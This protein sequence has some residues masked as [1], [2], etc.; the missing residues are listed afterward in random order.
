[1]RNSSVLSPFDQNTTCKIIQ[2]TQKKKIKK[3]IITF[4]S[5]KIPNNA[6]T[7]PPVIIITISSVT[8]LMKHNQRLRNGGK[9]KKNGIKIF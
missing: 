4:V 2:S 9:R 6:I 5:K 8:Q 3:F 1:M 7:K